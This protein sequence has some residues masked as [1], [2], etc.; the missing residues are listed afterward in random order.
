LG[1]RRGGEQSNRKKIDGYSPEPAEEVDA[2]DEGQVQ[3]DGHE[4]EGAR[5]GVEAAVD[6][7]PGEARGRR[8]GDEHGVHRV[9]LLGQ[10]LVGG[11]PLVQRHEHD[12][13]V[14]DPDGPEELAGLRPP[15]PRR[16][17][18][19]DEVAHHREVGGRVGHLAQPPL[20]AG[21]PLPVDLELE[22]EE[23]QDEGAP[24]GWVR[25]LRCVGAGQADGDEHGRDPRC[26]EEV[27]ADRMEVLAPDGL[28]VE[29]ALERVGD[30]RR[31]EHGDGEQPERDVDHGRHV[32]EAHRRARRQRAPEDGLAAEAQA[33]TEAADRK[34]Q[35]ERPHLILG[36]QDVLVILRKRHV[37]RSSVRQRACINAVCCACRGSTYADFVELGAAERGEVAAGGDALVERVLRR[38]ADGLVLDVSRQ[39]EVGLPDPSRQQRVLLAQR[40]LGA[41]HAEVAPARRAV[42]AG[43]AKGAAV[44][45]HPEAPAAAREGALAPT[46]TVPAP[47][48]HA[49]HR[50]A[51]AERDLP[52]EGALHR[53]WPPLATDAERPAHRRLPRV[54]GRGRVEV[55]RVLARR[56][57][58]RVGRHFCSYA[59]SAAPNNE[60][61]AKKC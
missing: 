17:D 43:R 58:R 45:E 15:D 53:R 11:Q 8:R 50:H 59:I 37:V 9:Q 12:D 41:E 36:Q 19:P 39:F 28:E 13:V 1:G 33:Q 38:P 60:I 25:P 54:L 27:D 34:P 4:E 56:R 57:R 2:H 23:R 18:G 26:E 44:V 29:D 7:G 61:R 31:D 21:E 5:H 51:A 10:R 46:S 52:A 24:H 16:Q 14:R 30:G 40:R 47:S 22:R 42:A 49:Q 32:Q 20:A 3:E 48:V 35:Q 55:I 6:R